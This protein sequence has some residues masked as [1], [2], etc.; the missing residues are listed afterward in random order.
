MGKGLDVCLDPIVYPFS[1][2]DTLQGLEPTVPW[3]TVDS[4]HTCLPLAIHRSPPLAALP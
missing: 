3:Y 4:R 1:I 2:G